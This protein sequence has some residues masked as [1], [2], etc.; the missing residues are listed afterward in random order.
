MS[1][2][3]VTRSTSRALM[4]RAISNSSWTSSSIRSPADGLTSANTGAT[5][6]AIGAATISKLGT[7]TASDDTAGPTTGPWMRKSEAARLLGVAYNTVRHRCLTGRYRTHRVYDDVELVSR[8]DVEADL[9][10][11]EPEPEAGATRAA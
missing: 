10:P 7:M 1:D 3:P 6:G 5:V 2:N 9:K 11:D 8:E 4:P